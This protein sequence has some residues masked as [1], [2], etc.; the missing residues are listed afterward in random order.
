MVILVCLL[1]WR[2]GFGCVLNQCAC[3]VALLV[4]VLRCDFWVCVMERHKLCL[5]ASVVLLDMR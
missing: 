2:P 4:W 3:L 5:C 1:D